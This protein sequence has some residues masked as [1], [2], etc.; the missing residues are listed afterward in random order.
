ME[1]LDQVHCHSWIHSLIATKDES[2]II[3]PY[4]RDELNQIIEEEFL[5]M[6]SSVRIINSSSTHL[7]CLFNLSPAKSVQQLIDR[8]KKV[9]SSF[10]NSKLET[11]E[12][13]VWE[14]DFSCLSVDST[15]IEEV[16]TFIRDQDIRNLS[17]PNKSEFSQLLE[18]H[19]V[20]REIE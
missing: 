16:Y 14:K 4:F 18:L 6:G 15:N 3:Q 20:T 2:P 5:K 13:S 7:N 12:H 17:E 9:S 1:N 10:I 19:N 11:Q 8:I